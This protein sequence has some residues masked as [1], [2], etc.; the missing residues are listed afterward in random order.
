MDDDLVRSLNKH[1]D[2]FRQLGDR[3]PVN[4]LEAQ[5]V[6]EKIRED[7]GYLDDEILRDLRKLDQRS[8][9]RLL[10]MVKSNRETEAAYTKKYALSSA[11]ESCSD[12][13]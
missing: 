1:C 10:R 9:D 11:V 12:N 2:V 7:K 4:S 8:H 5:A 13:L 6:I 3:E